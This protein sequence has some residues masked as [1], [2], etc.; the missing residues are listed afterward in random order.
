MAC[1]RL[2]GFTDSRREPYTNAFAE[3]RA[4]SRLRPFAFSAAIAAL[5][6]HPVPCPA[7]VLIS[8]LVN[9]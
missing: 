7:R 3:T 2:P 9:L 8:G 5:N 6:V 4:F 1:I